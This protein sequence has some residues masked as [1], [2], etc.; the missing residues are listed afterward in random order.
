MFV[1]AACAGSYSRCQSFPG[2]VEAEVSGAGGRVDA[3]YHVTINPNGAGFTFSAARYDGKEYPV[4]VPRTLGV[5]LNTGTKPARTA[6]F[7]RKDANTVR[8]TDRVNGW[9]S[10]T[11]VNQVS[12][13]GRTM[14]ETV[15]SFDQQGK[16]TSTS[17]VVFDKQKLSAASG[18]FLSCFAESMMAVSAGASFR[19]AGAE[20]LNDRM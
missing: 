5:F 18:Y 15:K 8:R 16:Q 11:G 6:A 12:E 10:S 20:L 7:V 3:P 2:I 14:T 9:T 13:D 4:Y 1:H 17:V 19:S